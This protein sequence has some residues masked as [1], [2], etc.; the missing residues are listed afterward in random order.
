MKSK[1][2]IIIIILFAAWL[3]LYVN[4]QVI[5]DFLVDKVS[6]TEGDTHLKESI[7]FFIFEVPKVMLLLI[8]IIF[9]VGVVRSFFS[10]E[11]TRKALEGKPLFG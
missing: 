7:R 2:I 1:R 6:T 3:I 11:Q 4:L 10:P 5:A 8:L 9:V